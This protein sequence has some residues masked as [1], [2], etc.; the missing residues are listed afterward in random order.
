MT[1]IISQKLAKELKFTF[2]VMKNKLNDN[3]A[4]TKQY[5]HNDPGNFA[6]RM[7]KKYALAADMEVVVPS[8]SKRPLASPI[9]KGTFFPANCKPSSVTSP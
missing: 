9:P 5:E 6:P 7:Y 1:T 3:R 8:K 4:E 2:K